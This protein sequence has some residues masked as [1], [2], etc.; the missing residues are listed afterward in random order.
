MDQPF[1]M[2]G[3][4]HLAAIALTF[5]VPLVFALAVRA[6]GSGRLA[7]VLRWA[8]AVELIATYALWYWLL[9]QRGWM[10]VGNILPMH[11]CDW[12]AIACIVTLV[13]P[14]QRTYELAYFWALTGTL[15]ATLT[16]SL[17]SAGRTGASWC[18]SASTAA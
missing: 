12:A 7:N 9:W 2:F 6:S 14:N 13:V 5:A 1:V 3:T 18:S 15:Q 8:F 4:A 16:P 11:L 10:A 17:R